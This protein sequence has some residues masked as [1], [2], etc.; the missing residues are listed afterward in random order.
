MV[1]KRRIGESAHA[2][3][4]Q[5]QGKAEETDTEP[6]VPDS[7]GR[8]DGQEEPWLRTN[9]TAFVIN[10]VY[11][12]AVTIYVP[13]VVCGKS[14][15]A[16]VDS[17]AEVTVMSE[18][19]YESLP[20]KTRPS[21]QAASQALVVADKKSRLRELGMTVVDIV[22]ADELHFQW[23][24]YVASIAD[25]FLL[26]CDI[27]DAKDLLVSPRQ[28]LLAGKTWLPCEVK[29]MPCVARPARVALCETI[30]IPGNHEIVFPVR[31]QENTLDPESSALLEPA[32][33]GN[34]NV[35]VARS[36]VTV[37]DHIP[38]R[39]I[40]AG[41]NPVKLP[42]GHLIGELHPVEEELATVEDEEVAVR[43]LKSSDEPSL[44]LEN[45]ATDETPPGGSDVGPA[46]KT[47]DLPEHLQTL[48]ADSVQEDTPAA[49]RQKLAGTLKRRHAAFASH[50]LDGGHFV[51]IK[52]QINTACAAPVRER[53]RRTPQGFE[54]EEE[55]CLHEQ[56][57]AGIIRPSSSPWAAA[58]VLVR[59]ADG[60]VRWCVDRQKGM[61]AL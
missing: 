30:T 20:E 38:V 48:Y 14:S 19:L 23:P 25:P 3:S 31:L 59:K 16:V 50:R 56:L 10:R 42:N 46:I 45:T 60:S 13:I 52:H 53:V 4:D 28:G 18:S 15:K 29:R 7:H 9:S 26:G 44:A 41:E 12:N 55:A 1:Q 21:L 40:N 22:I 11:I 39:F 57:E 35:L 61:S 43:I 27:L 51:P 2:G 58:T 37:G 32:C 33:H 49:I 34:C 24:V 36:M 47:E 6:G 5:P 8:M 17:G 54:K